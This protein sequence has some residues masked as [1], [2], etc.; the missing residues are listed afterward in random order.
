MSVMMRDAQQ[1]MIREATTYGEE[2]QE[3]INYN[4]HSK[5]RQNTGD[6]SKIAFKY[7]NRLFQRMTDFMEFE[8]LEISIMDDMKPK[9]VTAR[10]FLCMTQAGNMIQCFLKLEQP[11]YMSVAG[12]VRVLCCMYLEEAPISK[13]QNKSKQIGNL[14]HR[15][16]A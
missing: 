14:P 10:F 6:L 9:F 7:H 1:E 3:T 13:S 11:A 12:V 4:F 5:F 2:P 15:A 8:K 16:K